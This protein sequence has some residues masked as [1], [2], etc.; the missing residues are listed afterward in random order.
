MRIFRLL[1]AAVILFTV[2]SQTSR[3]ATYFDTGNELLSI[4][5]DNTPFK[6]GICSAAPGAYF[7]MM[8]S[9]G[10]KCDEAGV[11]R[12]QV[13][14]VLV[15]YLRDHPETR[16]RPASFLAFLAFRES[17]NCRSAPGATLP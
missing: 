17:F 12:G 5:N 9:I 3:A 11:T 16:N 2:S 8:A 13:R 1:F 7:D 15:K 10:Y 4:C 6:S 14:D